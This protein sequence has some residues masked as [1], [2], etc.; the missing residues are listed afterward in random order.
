MQD[1]PLSEDTPE[2]GTPLDSFILSKTKRVHDS[3]SPTEHVNQGEG[4]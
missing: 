1:V 4:D 3:T 2:C